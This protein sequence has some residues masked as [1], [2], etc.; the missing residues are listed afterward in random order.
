M[1]GDPFPGFIFNDALGWMPEWT[2]APIQYVRLSDRC[3]QC[4]APLGEHL[5]GGSFHPV[6]RP[7]LWHWK[8]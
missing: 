8:E 7:A 4:G 1:T 3:T 2:P 5:I 6:E